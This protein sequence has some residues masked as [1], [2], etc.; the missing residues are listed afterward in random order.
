MTNTRITDPEILERRYRESHSPC[1]GP[2]HFVLTIP[3]LDAR[4]A[5]ILHQFGYRPGSGGKGLYNGGDG[6]IREMEFLEP[7]EVSLL[8][9]RRARRPYG[10]AGG[11]DGQSG[12]NLQ[13]T[14]RK[15]TVDGKEKVVKRERNLGGKATVAFDAGDRLILNTP[16]GGGWGIAGGVEEVRNK[17]ETF[18]WE[19][20][21]SLAERTAMEAAFGA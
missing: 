1:T 10:M 2:F 21:G 5:V 15:V 7:I 12:L 17:V 13:V 8:T 19:P 4:P 9:E 20:R 11:E 16:G 18:G 3:T 14:E 6:V